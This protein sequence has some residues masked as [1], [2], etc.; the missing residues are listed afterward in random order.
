MGMGIGIH[1]R[2]PDAGVL[3]ERQEAVACGIWFT[4][5]GVMMPKLLKYQD[6][7][8]VIKSLTDIRV[9]TSEKKHYCGIPTAEY[10]C[11]GSLEGYV[12]RFRLIYYMEKNEWKILWK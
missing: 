6:S 12:R 3:R 4:S 2:T 9:I 11:E 8:G 10:V 5:T 7:R 1:S